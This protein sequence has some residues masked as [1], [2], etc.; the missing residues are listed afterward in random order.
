MLNKDGREVLGMKG[1]RTFSYTQ[2]L[3]FPFIVIAFS[4]KREKQNVQKAGIKK[5]KNY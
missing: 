4:F 5:F 3:S 1:S 2:P